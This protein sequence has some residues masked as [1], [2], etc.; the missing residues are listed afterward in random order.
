LIANNCRRSIEQRLTGVDL[1]EQLTFVVK[2]VK[3]PLTAPNSNRSRQT[4]G[5]Q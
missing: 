1:P 3:I 2:S 5:G 4:L